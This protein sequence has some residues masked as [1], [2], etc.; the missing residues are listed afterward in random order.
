MTNRER[1]I[2]ALKCGRPDAVPI[3]EQGINEVCIIDAMS[4]FTDDLPPRKYIHEM[5]PMEQLKLLETYKNLIINLDMDGITVP[6][7]TGREVVGANRIRDRLG[8]V[9]QATPHGEPFPIEGPIKSRDDLKSYRMPKIDDSFLMGAMYAVSQFRGSRA[10]VLHSP[11]PFKLSW[12]LRGK[13][14]SLLTDFVLD[15][16]LAH[17]LARLAVDYCAE[18]FEKA[19]R[20]GVDAIVLEGDLAMNETTLMSPKHYREFVKP[21]HS[22]ITEA[23]HKAGALIIKHSDGNLWPILD[24][25]IEA[26]FDGIHPIQPQC[27][28]IGDVKRHC[29][30]RAAVLGNID[31]I[32]VLVSGTPEEVE[33]AV[34][35]TI[36]AAAPGGGYILSS[37]NSIHPDV[38]PENFIAMARAARKFGQYQII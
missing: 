34:R 20:I 8:I 21:Y 17:S 9:S 27:M 12:A 30:G 1:F 24:D 19:I 18:L 23:V 26:G 3:W 31:C 32:G 37:S 11:G 4:H 7:L 5:N 28:D 15:P 38:K 25:L 16:E 2:T 36:S 6:T 29:A 13:M 35:M 22:R 33:E 10:V 14:E